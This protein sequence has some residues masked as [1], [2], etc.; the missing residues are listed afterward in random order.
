MAKV[1]Y[2]ERQ[3]AVYAQGRAVSPAMPA[4]WMEV[5]ARHAGNRGWLRRARR[6]G[7]HG[8]FRAG[9]RHRVNE[10]FMRTGARG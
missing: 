7:G 2:D 10:S 5:F 3:F 1:D 9:V 6:R 8:S 4:T